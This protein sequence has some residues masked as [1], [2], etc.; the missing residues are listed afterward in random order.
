MGLFALGA[1]LIVLPVLLG[2]CRVLRAIWS[3]KFWAIF[4]K[5]TMV[6]F[7]INNMLCIADRT[8][9]MHAG[10][11]YNFRVFIMTFHMHI[12][13]FVVSCIFCLIYEAPASWLTHYFFYP[14]I[15]EKIYPSTLKDVPRYQLFNSFKNCLLYTSD[16]ADDTPCVDLGGRRIIK[17]KKKEDVTEMNHLTQNTT[18]HNTLHQM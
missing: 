7:L 13:S 15:S 11:L 1:L 12:Y 5:A 3:A 8:S 2:K 4:S 10:Y 6:A 17:K 9:E 14:S 16:A 18:T